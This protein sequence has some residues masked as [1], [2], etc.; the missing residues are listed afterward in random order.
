VTPIS[1][2]KTKLRVSIS[3]KNN[4]GEY[5][6][7]FSDFPI[8]LGT[9]CAAK[10]ARLKEGDVIKLGDVDVSNRYVKE[11]SITYYDFKIFSFELANDEPSG[12]RPAARP[13]PKPV[14]EVEPESAD[15]NDL[16]F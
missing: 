8:C 5:V 11:K 9:A 10:A 7:E 13:A 4:E 3:R 12:S 1:D 15:D 14:D 2:R 16:P 6:Q